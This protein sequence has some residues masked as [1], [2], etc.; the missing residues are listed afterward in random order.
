MP[1]H[2]NAALAL[3]PEEPPPMEFCSVPEAAKLLGCDRKTVLSAIHRRQLPAAK[4][5]HNWRI[6]MAALRRKMVRRS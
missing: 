4:I 2:A 1:A 6:D 5:G 3:D